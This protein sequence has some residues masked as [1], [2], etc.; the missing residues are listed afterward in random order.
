MGKACPKTH[1]NAIHIIEE[2]AVRRPESKSLPGDLLSAPCNLKCF[3]GSFH[4]QDAHVRR[5]FAFSSSVRA[6]S[7]APLTTKGAI[8]PSSCLLWLTPRDLN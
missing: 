3:F 4:W 6:D 5:D 1:F 8:R 7:T 2:G